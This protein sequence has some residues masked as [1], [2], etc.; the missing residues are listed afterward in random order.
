MPA[1]QEMI[2]DHALTLQ[3]C[4]HPKEEDSLGI[5]SLMENMKGSAVRVLI[6]PTQL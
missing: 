5:V 3:L 6:Q 2:M 1:S 4:A